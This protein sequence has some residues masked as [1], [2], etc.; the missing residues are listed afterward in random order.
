MIILDEL[1]GTISRF[2]AQYNIQEI[3]GYTSE[4]RRSSIPLST[5]QKINKKNT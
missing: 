4:P 3:T 1:K 5:L 2:Q